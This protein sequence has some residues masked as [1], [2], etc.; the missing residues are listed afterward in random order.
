LLF[1]A[2]CVLALTALL[3]AVVPAAAVAAEVE[4]VPHGN[5]LGAAWRL[6]SGRS[7]GLRALNPLIR[8]GSRQTNPRCPEGYVFVA[9][10]EPRSSSERRYSR[11]VP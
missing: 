1:R 8:W 3:F 7:R 5:S 6:L 2:F 4:I 11:S 10:K 9:R